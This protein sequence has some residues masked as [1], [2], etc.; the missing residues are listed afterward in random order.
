MRSRNRCNIIETETQ[1]M[2][3]RPQGIV[4][5]VQFPTDGLSPQLRIVNYEFGNR[6]MICM[7]NYKWEMQNKMTIGFSYNP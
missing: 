2:S 5:T 3:G 7:R 4:P 6:D 1:G